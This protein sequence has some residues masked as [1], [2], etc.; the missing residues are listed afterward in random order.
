MI[1]ICFEHCLSILYIEQTTLPHQSLCLVLPVVNNEKY[2]HVTL[3]L[4]NWVWASGFHA[5]LVFNL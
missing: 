5:R 2:P 1:I 3:D 4:T